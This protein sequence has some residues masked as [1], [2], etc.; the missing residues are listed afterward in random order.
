MSYQSTLRANSYMALSAIGFT[1]FFFFMMIGLVFYFVYG[2][3]LCL[4]LAVLAA[5]IMLVVQVAISTSVVEWSTKIQYLRPGDMVE[6]EIKG[7]GKQ[8]QNF[9]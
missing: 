5:V 1:A 4:V 3:F 8:R 2:S 6:L 7:L 9:K